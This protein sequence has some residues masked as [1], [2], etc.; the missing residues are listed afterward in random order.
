MQ[1]NNYIAGDN[2]CHDLVCK[3]IQIIVAT[4]MYS[5][6]IGEPSIFFLHMNSLE[7]GEKEA[8]TVAAVQPNLSLYTMQHC[9]IDRESNEI[10]R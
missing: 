10:N 1:S 9:W 8:Y 6:I 7:K 4:D 2:T 3:Q 5:S